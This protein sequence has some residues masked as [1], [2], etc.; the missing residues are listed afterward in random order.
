M[1]ARDL[2]W[3]P[4][5]LPTVEV[6]MGGAQAVDEVLAGDDATDTADYQQRLGARLRAIRRSQGLRLQDVEDLSHGVFKAVVVG[7][8]ERGDR[9]VAAH[10]LAALAQL[11]N[12][13]VSDLLP[14]DELTEDASR[15]AGVTIAVEPLLRSS[16]PDLAVLKRL[17]RHVQRLRDETDTPVLTLRRSD[18]RI[19]AIAVGLPPESVEDWLREHELLAH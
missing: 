8:Y 13:P 2:R 3:A 6:D 10:K 15:S 16:D 5:A 11:Y 18:L 9:A 4:D 1:T 14:D 19:I 7:S 12:V 17:V